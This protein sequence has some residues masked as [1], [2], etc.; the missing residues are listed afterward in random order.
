[1]GF[2][3]DIPDIHDAVGWTLKDLAKLMNPYTAGDFFRGLE[4]KEGMNIY[5]M[6]LWAL[7]SLMSC[8]FISNWILLLIALFVAFLIALWYG[9]YTSRLLLLLGLSIFFGYAL[10][11]VFFS[12]P[13]HA[14]ITSIKLGYVYWMSYAFVPIATAIILRLRGERLIGRVVTN[15]EATSL[16]LYSIAPA[17]LT[18][19]FRLFLESTII[20]YIALAYSI[21]ALY[22]GTKIM[23]GFER[24]MYAFL[25]LMLTAAIAGMLL[26][27]LSTMFLGIPTPYY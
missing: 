23:L 17:L 3:L 26:L 27:V 13:V 15:E 4:A 22:L 10:H 18:G 9:N 8:V 11:F 7:L 20:H 19:I 25:A 2:R 12:Y 21:Y 16:T 1:M 6:F 5:V 24:A 14:V